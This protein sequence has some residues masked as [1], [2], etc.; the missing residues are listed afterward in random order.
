MEAVFEIKP[1]GAQEI[2]VLV[3][4]YYLL[5]EN[6]KR[7][8]N[9]IRDL[10][11]AG[12]SIDYLNSVYKRLVNLENDIKKTLTRWVDQN[13]GQLAE[14]CLSIIGIGPVITAGLMTLIDI[15]KAPTVGH[16]WRFAGLDPT[17]KWEKGQKRPH[18]A[19]LKTLCWKI[20]E[21]FV[22][23]LNKEGNLYGRLYLERKELET[24]KN[25]KLLFAEQAAEQLKRK[26][27]KKTTIAYKNYITGKLPP[28]HIHARAKRYAVKI[29]LSHYHH[30]AYEIRFGEKPPKPFVIEH[31]GHVDYIPAPNW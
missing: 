3:Y 15:E 28:G 20:G 21:S 23:T 14:W 31:L 24:A 16:I 25:D 29:F 7:A 6:R 30:V 18:N 22:K 13:G 1:I 12:Q 9:Q 17:A 11:K 19:E 8:G 26:N 5:Q 2:N 27:F 4:F 10:A